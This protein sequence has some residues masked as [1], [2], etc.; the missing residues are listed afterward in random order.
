[1]PTEA[2]TPGYAPAWF[3][4]TVPPASAAVS[5]AMRRDLASAPRSGASVYCSVTA[6]AGDAII[7]QPSYLQPI[8]RKSLEIATNAQVGIATIS[9]RPTTL[10]VLAAILTGE[11][12]VS[13]R[14]RDVL[15]L[16][17]GVGMEVMGGIVQNAARIR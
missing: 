1:M 12:I 15:D 14:F 13:V 2:L 4:I 10:D 9:R 17:L 7:R 3:K 16:H 6:N 5:G 11:P 8:R